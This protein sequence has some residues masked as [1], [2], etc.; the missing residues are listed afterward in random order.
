MRIHG[1]FLPL[2]LATVQL[3]GCTSAA[4]PLEI[5]V[6]DDSFVV[7]GHTL[8]TPKGLPDTIRVSGASECRVIPDRTAA[9][10]QVESAMLAL[11]ETGSHR[12]MSGQEL[13][14]ASVRYRVG[15][16]VRG[17]AVRSSSATEARAIGGRRV[18]V[19]YAADAVVRP[20]TPA[21]SSRCIGD[22]LALVV[23]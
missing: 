4:R 17:R 18:V 21:D 5:S 1:T 13:A 14:L 16:L 23:R 15:W 10:K 9:Y 7:G 8:K 12:R 6:T 19:G 22:M 3:M 11:R 20:D 2:A